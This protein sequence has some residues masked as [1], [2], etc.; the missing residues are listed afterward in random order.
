MT[1]PIDDAEVIA[2]SRVK[3]TPEQQF[4]QHRAELATFNAK[5][6]AREPLVKGMFLLAAVALVML[7]AANAIIG[8]KLGVACAI[9]ATG[10]FALAQLFL[11]D[12]WRG[13]A[14]LGWLFRLAGLGASA[15]S[16]WFLIQ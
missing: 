5:I 4:E 2:A 6:A 9:G 8:S 1:N 7:T 13:A 15:A 10:S 16:L 14:V 3:P 11:L 12:E